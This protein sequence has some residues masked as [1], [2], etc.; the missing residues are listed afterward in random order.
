[1]YLLFTSGFWIR[2]L[3]QLYQKNYL[4]KKKD[5][6]MQQYL[7]QILIIEIAQSIPGQMRRISFIFQ[8]I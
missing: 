7:L 8:V 4:S 5:Y 2:N 3:A 1:M 6:G